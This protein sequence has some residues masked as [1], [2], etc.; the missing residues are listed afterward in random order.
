[1]QQLTTDYDMNQQPVVHLLD[2]NIDHGVIVTDEN[3]IINSDLTYIIT[4]FAEDGDLGTYVINNNKDFKKGRPESQI[5]TIFKQILDGLEAIH[6]KG[7]VHLDLKPENILLNNHLEVMIS[8]F[9][10]SKPIKGE[11]GKGNFTR[12]KAGSLSYWSPEMYIDMPYNGVSS[13]LYAL[14]VILFVLTFG[15]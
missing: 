2:S 6:N 12:Y 7:F 11:D 5:F 13:D 8:D 9:A 3:V 14:G 10:L 4:E 15:S 1:M